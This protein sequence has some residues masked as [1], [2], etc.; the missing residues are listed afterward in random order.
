MA[1]PYTT[2]QNRSQGLLLFPLP[3][4][5]PEAFARWAQQVQFVIQEQCYNLISQRVE[6]MMLHGTLA[7][8]PTADGS[9]RF[10]VATDQVP[11]ELY[12]DDGTWHGPL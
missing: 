11:V 7:N 12:F 8:R 10:Y 5:R 4:K 6:E 9:I 3:P 2:G 1:N